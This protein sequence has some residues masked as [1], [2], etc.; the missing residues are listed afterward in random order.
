MGITR[1]KDFI[2]NKELCIHDVSKMLGQTSRVNSSHKRSSYKHMSE[3]EWF[4][5]LI[6][7]LYS[8]RCTSAE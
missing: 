3:N 7:I 6:E 8:T 5:S 4:L 2:K 1:V